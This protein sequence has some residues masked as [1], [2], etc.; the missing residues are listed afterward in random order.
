MAASPRL[1][2]KQVASI[3]D[4]DRRV[5]LWEGAVRSGKTIGSLVR[6]LIFVRATLARSGQ[7]VMFGRTRDA[8]WRNVIGPLQDAELFGRVASQVIGN[9][10]APTV[11][12]FGR[13]VHV[14]GASDA[15]AEKVIRGMTVLGAY[16]DELTVV[17]E[18]FFKQMLARMSTPWSRMFGTTNPDGPRHWL[19]VD[20]LDRVAGWNGNITSTLPDW[21]VFHFN[22]ED[23]PSLTTSYVSSLKRE[24][25]GLWYK[26]FILGLW[27]QAEG[28]IYDMWDEATHIVPHASLPAMIRTPGLGVDYGTTNAT[29]GIMLGLSITPQPRLYLVDEW[30]PGRMSPA[31]HSKD[32]RSWLTTRAPEWIYVDPAAAAFKEQLFA[33]RVPNVTDATNDVVSGIRTMSA[34]LAT[35]NLLVSD[36]C[37][38]LIREIPGYVWDD[39]ATERGLDA[40]VKRD[41]HAMD[42][43]RYVVHSTR[44]LWR[45]FLPVLTIDQDEEEAA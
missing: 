42:A 35:G 19:K 32:L 7:L 16:G 13:R 14:L 12:I 10:G 36:R 40:P 3:R 22:L 2:A 18:E 23:N 20:F 8:V 15:K 45:P 30:A 9:Y 29:R 5:N 17:P 6:W 43:A 41:D 28:A 11:S 44:Y 1:S 31:G 33:D 27:V 24:Y 4:A 34:L 38:N 25:T 21:R 39:K 37:R 26:R